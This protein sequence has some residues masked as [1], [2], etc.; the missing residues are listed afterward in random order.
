[1]SRFHVIT[2][3][4][5]G[6]TTQ[7]AFTAAE[8]SAQDALDAAALATQTRVASFQTDAGRAALIAQLQAATPAQIKTFITNQ[9]TDLASA[10]QMLIA[11]ALVI[12]LDART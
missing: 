6:E 7:V 11:L 9:V 4:T 5:T 8:E 3:A 1:M 2:D 12:A 10:R